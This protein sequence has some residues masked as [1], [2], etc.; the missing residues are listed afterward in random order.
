VTDKIAVTSDDAFAESRSLKTYTETPRYIAVEGPIGAGKT[1]LAELISLRLHSQ[2][3]LERY[4]ENPFLAQFYED[5]KRYGFQTQIF[6][7][8]SR[9]RQQQD[10]IQTDLFYQ[11]VVSDY[12]FPKDQIFANVTLSED[13]LKLYDQIASALG[14]TV[15][16]PDV[17][18]YLQAG[19]G[20]LEENIRRRGRPYERK[21]S[22][23][24][25][26]SL[27]NAY[28][29]F[30]FHYR[31]TRLIVVDASRMEFLT[32]PAHVE[33]LLEAIRRSPHPPVEYLSAAPDTQFALE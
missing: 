1:T 16:T 12:I 30:F 31:D 9:Y 33:H 7:L 27:V 5:P 20:K 15:P 26:E 28:N 25:L 10:L 24:Y 14:K 19:V 18:I 13:E 23:A 3:I 21:V 17:V 8:L 22:R 11:S 4:E 2:L 32:N 6:F 29:D